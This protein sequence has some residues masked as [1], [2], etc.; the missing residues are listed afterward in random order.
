MVSHDYILISGYFNCTQT[1][2]SCNTNLIIIFSK[3]P[4]NDQSHYM[5]L[6]N[7]VTQNI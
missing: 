6:S 2:H 5:I 7:L 3:S 4:C 1:F